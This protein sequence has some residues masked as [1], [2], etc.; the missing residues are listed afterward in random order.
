MNPDL[1]RLV[2]DS[3][4]WVLERVT[5][6][7][8]LCVGPCLF[9]SCLPVATNVNA[10]LLIDIYDGQGDQGDLKC[11][12]HQIYTFPCC[13]PP[14]PAYFRRGLYVNLTTNAAA[15]CIQYLPLKD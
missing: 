10:A 4:E 8:C 5:E 2:D 1:E 13:S 9:S 14:F 11:S 3:K 7:R 12:I 6:S 15:A